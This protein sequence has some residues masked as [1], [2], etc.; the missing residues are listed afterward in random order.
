MKNIDLG[1]KLE[2]T[3]YTPEIEEFCFDFEYEVIEEF[4]SLTDIVNNPDDH[5]WR[6][7]KFPGIV[8]FGGYV[9]EWVFILADFIYKKYVRVKHLDRQDIEEEGWTF[10]RN[11]FPA[12]P[13]LNNGYWIKIEDQGYCLHH[14]TEIN[15]I[16]IYE[17]NF[18]QGLGTLFRG[19]I[20]NKS[21]LRRLMK[22]LGIT[23]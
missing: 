2:P 18:D 12:K 17:P 11:P 7:M 20:K 14:N 22:Q 15:H 13:W 10:S 4:G 3:Y 23:K 19:I 9:G 6:K 5:K 16:Y 21:E 1:I 8:A